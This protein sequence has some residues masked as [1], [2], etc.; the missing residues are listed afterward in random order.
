MSNEFATRMML[1]ECFRQ[2]ERHVIAD[3]EYNRT[4]ARA[5]CARK[6]R[7]DHVPLHEREPDSVRIT[8]RSRPAGKATLLC[9]L[10]G[11]SPACFTQ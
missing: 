6:D 8:E 7:R 10:N 5:R 11:V 2:A 9:S 1:N 3:D 4:G